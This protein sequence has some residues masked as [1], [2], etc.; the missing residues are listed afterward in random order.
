MSSKD[1]PCLWDARPGLLGK[2]K[3][4]CERGRSRRWCRGGTAGWLARAAHPCPEPR[5][6]WDAARARS[7]A[8]PS[9]GRPPA[10]PARPHTHVEGLL[11]QRRR[12]GRALV[13]GG[14][15][16]VHRGGLVDGA[17]CGGLV[18]LVEGAAEE[19][20]EV[21]GA[22][23][24]LGG[25]LP[26]SAEGSPE[27]LPVQLWFSI[28]A[29]QFGDGRGPGAGQ[30][31]PRHAGRPQPCHALSRHLLRYSLPGHLQA[32]FEGAQVIDIHSHHLGQS[33]EEVLGLA[34]HV[35][36]HD[37]VGQA[38]QLCHLEKQGGERTR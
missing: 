7:C 15:P 5:H 18:V 9:A 11:P 38:L 29:A 14:E 34:G 35:A 37:V 33:C 26:C 21:R 19:S 17:G 28:I 2:E 36:H 32:E 20:R 8:E 31:L 12:V 3:R 23:A 4:S 13:V 1:H 30:L 22:P 27:P 16:L 24:S 6:H 10:Q 25:P